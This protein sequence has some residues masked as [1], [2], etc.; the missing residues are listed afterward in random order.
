MCPGSREWGPC[1]SSKVRKLGNLWRHNF[2]SFLNVGSKNNVLVEKTLG[3]VQQ[4]L[5]LEKPQVPH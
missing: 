5:G 2:I 4:I 1:R 3:K